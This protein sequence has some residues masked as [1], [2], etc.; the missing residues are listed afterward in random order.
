M[1][2]EVSRDMGVVPVLPD[3]GTFPRTPANGAQWIHPDDDYLHL[4][5]DDETDH[6]ADE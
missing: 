4:G 2:P 6:R 3:Y 1:S 5:A